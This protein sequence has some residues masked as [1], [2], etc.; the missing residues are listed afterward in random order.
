MSGISQFAQIAIPVAVHD[1]YTYAIPKALRDAVRLGSRVEV[2]LGPKITTGFVIGLVDESAVDAAKMKPIRA[3]LDDEEPALIP[4]IIELCRWAAEYYIAP[5]G[6]MLRV[7]LPAN[8]AARGKRQAVLTA[9]AAM[10]DDALAKKQILPAD[11]AIVDELS[12]RPLP[13]NALFEEMKA[14]RTAVARLRDAGII[15]IQDRLRDA[16]GVRYDRFVILETSPGALTAK[17]QAAVELLASRG[18]ELS[19]R[20]LEHGG[21]TA[22]VLSALL[23]KGVVRVERRA[24]RHTLD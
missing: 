5:P 7:A 3:V 10:I 13:L 21:V 16:E 19:V 24:R 8:M 23:K 12:R 6:E 14:S 4:E 18:G 2:P 11:V 22:A 1:T 20:A 9:D 17:Q 15:A